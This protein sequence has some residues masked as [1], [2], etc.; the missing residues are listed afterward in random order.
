LPE[1]ALAATERARVRDR[2]D[3]QWIEDRLTS[4]KDIAQKWA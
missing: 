4:A 2:E 3:P 1:S